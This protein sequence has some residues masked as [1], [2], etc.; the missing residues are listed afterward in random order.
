MSLTIAYITSR[1]DPKID[2][3]WDSLIKQAK[4]TH[5]VIVVTLHGDIVE[6]KFSDTVR[7]KPSVWQGEYRLTK[8]DWFAAANARNTALCMC[9]TEWIAYVDDLSVLMPGWLGRVEA[10]MEGGYNVAGSYRKVK[11]LWVKDGEVKWSIPFSDDSRLNLQKEDLSD[12]DGGWLYGCSCAFRVEDLLS[13]GGWPEYCDGLGSEDYCLG[14]CLKNAGFTL[15]Y[16]KQ[17][18]TYESEEDH[19]KEPSLKRTDKGLSPN[20]KSHAA[21]NIAKSSKY[22]ANYYRGGMRT[23]REFVLKGFPFP[24]IQEPKHDWFDNQPISEM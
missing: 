5:R 10:A 9:E 8:E 1:K 3:F 20:D 16:D 11:E 17:M 19:Y 23:L 21:L 18:M 2:W 4:E 12:C 15:K 7:P 13:V 22:F 6:D 14:L 24:V